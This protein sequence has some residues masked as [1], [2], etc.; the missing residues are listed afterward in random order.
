MN[1]KPINDPG[2]HGW[3]G[4]TADRLNLAV[5]KRLAELLDAWALADVC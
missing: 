1:S 2:N 4:A 3:Q 5:G